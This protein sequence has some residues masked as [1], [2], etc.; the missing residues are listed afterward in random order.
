MQHAHCLIR[1]YNFAG[2]RHNIFAILTFYESTAALHGYA[3]LFQF[4]HETVS[5]LE[6]G[7]ITE[8][9]WSEESWILQS[10]PLSS[11]GCLQQVRRQHSS[12]IWPFKY[13]RPLCN[14]IL[15]GKPNTDFTVTDMCALQKQ[16]EC[17]ISH[18][19]G[20]FC[21]CQA[22]NDNAWE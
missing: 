5:S 18:V 17:W 20:A 1:A 3:V 4:T 9:S 13:P 22:F 8:D 12:Y 11:S 16:A 21:T 2:S 7:S 10:P 15:R 19:V 14:S 6:S